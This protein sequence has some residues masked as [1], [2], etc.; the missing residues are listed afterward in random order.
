MSPELFFSVNLLQ[1][2]S[3]LPALRA[4]IAGKADNIKASERKLVRRDVVVQISLRSHRKNNEWQNN[5]FFKLRITSLS[6]NEMFNGS[7][8]K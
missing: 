4:V 2:H 8:V 5:V 1:Q 6:I 3:P 7:S